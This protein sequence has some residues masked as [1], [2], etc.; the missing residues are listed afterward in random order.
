VSGFSRTAIGDYRNKPAITGHRGT[1]ARRGFPGFY[2]QEREAPEMAGTR[3]FAPGVID[4]ESRMS[5][6]YMSARALSRE[7]A[8]IW[9]EILGPFVQRVG[10]ARIVDV[11][12]GTGRFASLF[13][14]SFTVQVIGVEPSRG[15]LKAGVVD[16]QPANLAYVAGRAEC[17]PLR[18]KSCDVAWLSHVW[19]H[20][21]DH[22]GCAR[23]LRRI[24]RPA[25]YV[26]VRGTF[27]DLLDG[28]PT[29]FR[30]WPA[31]R[32][33][34]R[35]LPTVSKTVEVFDANGFVLTEQRRV[36][37]MTSASLA[38]FA[39]RTRLR[40]DTALALISD[41]E[42]REGQAAIEEAAAAEQAPAPVIEGIE[43][44]VFQENST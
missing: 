18:D 42:F 5:P 3:P 12:A 27:G 24:L 13:A 9:C 19:H 28:F 26:L 2:R 37:Q 30:Y 6:N 41:S 29:L 44:L 15:M 25:C 22:H 4:Y 40:A 17:I 33:V 31:T 14:R 10:R 34:C 43:L 35:Q 32:E 20:V 23:E 7:A 39:E 36:H 11:G 38:G 21:Q 1:E 8:S 16:P